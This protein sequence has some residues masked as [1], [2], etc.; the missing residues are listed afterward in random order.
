MSASAVT[1]PAIAGFVK[2][3]SGGRYVKQLCSHW[4]HKLPVEVVSEEGR[5]L[6]TVTFPDA[7]V[8]M[9][10][11]AQGIAVTIAGADREAVARLPDV[12]AR[13]IDRFAFREAPLTY[14]WEW[15]EAAGGNAAGGKAGP[16][17]AA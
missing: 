2:T 17:V 14:E 10:A 13:H 16:G 3:D 1:G 8:T 5:D 6:G 7:V 15:R 4:G 9:A 11:D 12:V